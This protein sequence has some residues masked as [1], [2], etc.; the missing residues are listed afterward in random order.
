LRL[1]IILGTVILGI[2][3]LMNG[4]AGKR[5]DAKNSGFFKDYTQLKSQNDYSASKSVEKVDLSKYKTILIA[6]ALVVSAIPLQQQTV[7]QKRFYKEISNYLDEGYKREIQKSTKYKIVEKKGTDTLI[8]E[9][10]VSAVEVHFD[11][12]K[13]NQFSPIAMDIT[14]TS[15]NSYMDENVRILGEKRIVDSATDKVLIESMNI[16]KDKKVVLSADVLD[17]EAIKPALDA[18]IEHVKNY[19]AD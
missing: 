8:F 9:S 7:S 18:W 11:D 13:W 19:F 1:Q 14:V 6:P 12:K 15:Y 10:A 16:I 4:C 17:L 2:M 5:T 3:F